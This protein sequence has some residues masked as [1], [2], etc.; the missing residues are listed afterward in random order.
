MSL[1]IVVIGAGIGQDILAMNAQRGDDWTQVHNA[2]LQ[3]AVDLG[4]PG[5]VLPSLRRN[6]R[7]SGSRGRAARDRA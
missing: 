7:K 6:R 2:Y 1:N 4:V 5:V 3:Y